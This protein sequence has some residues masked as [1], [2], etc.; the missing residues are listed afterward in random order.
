[1]PANVSYYLQQFG[2]AR[3]KFYALGKHHEHEKNRL[4]ISVVSIFDDGVWKKVL[5]DDDG[6]I[7]LSR[8]G[9]KLSGEFPELHAFCSG[10]I[11]PDGKEF[12]L[13]ELTEEV[14]TGVA[15]SDSEKSAI[16]GMRR[17]KAIAAEAGLSIPD[18]IAFYRYALEAKDAGKRLFGNVPA[19][20]ATK[21]TENSD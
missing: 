4:N 2:L 17:I 12:K 5:P 21:S 3:V 9:C 6:V 18:A 19:L 15:F 11:T 14:R 8:R 16:L 13:D 10:K 7:K 1:M 20:D